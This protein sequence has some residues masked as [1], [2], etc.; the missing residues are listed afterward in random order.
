MLGVLTDYA[1][2][3]VALGTMIFALATSMIG[4]IS[5]LTRQ[6]LIG[7]TL[8][9]ASYPGVL[10]AFMV[11]QTRNSLIL[12]LG[13][14]LSGY[15]SYGLV[16]GLVRYSKQTLLNSLSLVSVSFFSLGMILKQF[17][18]GNPLFQGASQAG[19]SVYLFGQAAFITQD[20]VVLV[21][22][23]SVLVLL[24]F[25]RY[26]HLY[27]LYLFDKV[28][29]QTVGISTR[30]LEHLLRLLMIGLIAVGLKLVG[31]IL[32]SSF[33]IAP[34]SIGLLLGKH[35]LQTLGIAAV[36]SLSAAFLGTYLSSLVSGLS[37]GP[38]IILVMTLLF[39]LA[40]LCQKDGRKE[41][42]H[43]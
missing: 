23:V 4:T 38:S 12:M 42:S 18:Q 25:G 31:A 7:D 1:F 5:V 30:R 33:L 17:I 37:T 43:V 13:A 15:L 34:A 41:I 40:L 39:G 14:M 35:Y 32:I 19:L 22:A 8:G 10:L 36:M 27:K 2:W 9:H 16:Y 3:T 24:V 11:F 26:Y 20:D 6:S 21:L 29:A 28:L